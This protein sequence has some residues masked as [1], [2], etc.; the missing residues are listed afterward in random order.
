MPPVRWQCTA[1]GLALSLLLALPDQGRALPLT[2]P[3]SVAEAAKRADPVALADLLRRGQSPDARPFDESPLRLALESR[4][5]ACVRELLDAGAQFPARDANALVYANIGA[6][7]ASYFSLL[8]RSSP[9]A[10]GL[11][12]RRGLLLQVRDNRQ[13]TF[14]H[15]VADGGQA[16]TAR[17]LIR[18]G[19]AVDTRNAWGETPLI[20]A[21][22]DD[23]L[24]VAQVLF[25]AGAATGLHDDSGRT[26]KL[27][28]SEAGHTA[29]V[30]L[31]ESK[32]DHEYTGARLPSSGFDRELAGK[33]QFDFTGTFYKRLPFLPDNLRFFAVRLP[34]PASP[35]GGIGIPAWEPAAA[36]TAYYAVVPPTRVVKLDS[37]ADFVSL[38]L[39]VRTKA[40]SLQL[41]RVLTASEQGTEQLLSPAVANLGLE[42]WPESLSSNCLSTNASKLRKAGIARPQVRADTHGGQR[43]FV[44]V[45]YMKPAGTRPG[46]GQT[47]TLP[48]LFRVV[49]QVGADGRYTVIAR[50]AIRTPGL[51]LRNICF[52]Q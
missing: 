36:G 31:F 32:G 17:L 8:G 12:L 15:A 7:E 51:V 48:K 14:L 41:V 4:C 2:P 23:N 47:V 30:E 26:A 6:G 49:E 20:V 40:Q 37:A 22:R 39:H 46:F 11:F 38:G 24:A 3:Q 35:A 16:G 52:A 13:D 42:E 18:H 19:L 33:Q 50:Q 5:D 29:I 1:A 43:V 9:I 34:P 45:R 44:I 25:A 28:A 10:F 21:A 27:R